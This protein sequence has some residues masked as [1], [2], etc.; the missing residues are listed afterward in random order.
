M[1]NTFNMTAD[2]LND[3]IVEL[4]CDEERL[5]YMMKRAENFSQLNAI[6]KELDSVIK[7]RKYY[8]KAFAKGDY[9]YY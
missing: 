1:E 5:V 4:Y 8:E 6:R 7:T 9:R 3:R 2:E